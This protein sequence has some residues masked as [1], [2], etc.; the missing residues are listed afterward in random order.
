[1][2]FDYTYPTSNTTTTVDI[3]VTPMVTALPIVGSISIQA[4]NI[5][6]NAVSLEVAYSFDG[7]L[8]TVDYGAT[9]D[10]ANIAST[11]S[12]GA[13]LLNLRGAYM[14]VRGTATGGQTSVNLQI[15]T[16]PDY[17]VQRR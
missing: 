12:A 10:L 16:Q 6:A 4:S 17:A 14:R 13:R 5:G 8:Y 2:P 9:N 15:W 7:V 11:D 3:V 1:M